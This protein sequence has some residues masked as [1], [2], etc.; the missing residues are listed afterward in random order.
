MGL[1]DGDALGTTLD[2]RVP[3]SFEPIGDMVGGGPFSL[4]PGQWA[5]RYCNANIRVGGNSVSSRGTI[6]RGSAKCKASPQQ[7]FIMHLEKMASPTIGSCL[8]NQ[9]KERQRNGPRE[10]GRWPQFPTN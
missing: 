8:V 2:F 7:Q 3:G 5:K 4:D 9:P 6:P 1:A 10:A